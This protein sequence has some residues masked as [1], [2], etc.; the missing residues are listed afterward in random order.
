MVLVKLRG[1]KLFVK[2]G[3]HDFVLGYVVT[4][5]G[6]KISLFE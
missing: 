6:I 1:H 3:K 5:D 4:K 2:F